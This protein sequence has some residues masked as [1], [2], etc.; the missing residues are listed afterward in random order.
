M[1]KIY[2]PSKIR[3]LAATIGIFDGVHCGHQ[4]ILKKLV[5][6]SRRLKIKSLVV[7]FSPHPR[8]ILNPGSMIPFLTSLEHRSKLIENLGV[9]FFHMIR[10]TKPLSLMEPGEFVKKVLIDKFNIKM[11]VVGQDFLLGNKRGGDFS[12]LKSLSKKYNFRLFGVKPV[13]IKGKVI[14]STRIRNSIEKGDLKNASLM[15]GRPVS[16]LGTVVRGKAIGRKIGFPTAN[17]NPHHEAIP[18]SGVYAVDTRMD[19]K[20]YK[21]VLNIGIRPTLGKDKESTVEIHI[22]RFK[23]NIYGKDIE[24]I[25]KGK[26]RDEKK[27]PSLEKLRMQIKKDILNAKHAPHI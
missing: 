14:S 15:L 18:P 8:K 24:I 4:K 16:I 6:D 7:T 27:F 19:R 26:I 3:K 17:I 23:K 5:S 21:A 2:N 12:L 9:D 1:K 20:I 22:L 25:F 11:L 13:K 10:F